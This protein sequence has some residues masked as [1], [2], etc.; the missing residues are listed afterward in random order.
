MGSYGERWVFI[1]SY[2]ERTI[3]CQNGLGL[4]Y[5]KRRSPRDSTR[6][7]RAFVIR[8]P[9]MQRSAKKMR[10]GCTWRTTLSHLVFASGSRCPPYNY[11]RISVPIYLRKLTSFFARSASDASLA[12]ALLSSAVAA[13]ISPCLVA[14][15]ARR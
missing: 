1:G 6:S 11:K 12:I 8:R 4:A 5:H 10:Q 14:I 9:Q 15:T 7:V 2:G 3:S 13:A